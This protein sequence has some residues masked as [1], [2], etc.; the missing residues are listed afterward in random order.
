MNFRFGLAVFISIL[1][2]SLIQGEAENE[3]GE[4]KPFATVEESTKDP[5]GSEAKNNN[6]G[7]KNEEQPEIIVEESPD[8]NEGSKAKN[9]DDGLKNEEQQAQIVEESSDNNEGS[10]SK[11]NGDGS[12]KEEQPAKEVDESPDNINKGNCLDPRCCVR[13]P[14][15][16]GRTRGGFLGLR[17]SFVPDEYTCD[18]QRWEKHCNATDNLFPTCT[19]CMLTCTQNQELIEQECPHDNRAS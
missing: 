6:D 3:A 4:E 15:C 11:N 18:P 8:N 10:Q 9:N 12:K 7:P 13:A 2:G 17:W 1:L 16:T 5:E 19:D 14:E